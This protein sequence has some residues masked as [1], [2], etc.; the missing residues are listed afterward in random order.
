V[1]QYSYSSRGE[2]LEA[3]TRYLNP[4]QYGAA[5]T[6]AM[7]AG[8][9]WSY[10]FDDTGNLLRKSLSDGSWYTMIDVDD[11]NRISSRNTMSI[12]DSVATPG[13]IV[14]GVAAEGA[15]VYAGGK[16]QIPP[17]SQ[18]ALTRTGT[19]T[20]FK[21]ILPYATTSAPV[22]DDEVFLVAE[23][24]GKVSFAQRQ[25]FVPK[26]QQAFASD[27]DG[28]LTQDGRW[29]YSWNSLSQLTEVRPDPAALA[30]GHP[31]T[32][33]EYSYDSDGWRSEKR[34]YTGG[35]VERVRYLYYGNDLLAEVKETVNANGEATWELARGYHWMSGGVGEA[36]RLLSVQDYERVTT[37]LPGHDERGNVVTWTNC[38]TG[39]LIGTADYGP[40]GE[41]FDVRWVTPADEASYDRFGFGTEYRDETGL[42]YY[43][44]RYY[45]PAL[46]R[47]LS[48]DPAGVAGSGVNLYAFCGGDP[49]NKREFY[50]LCN[51]N[52]YW[53]QTDSQ[54]NSMGPKYSVGSPTDTNSQR[55][56][57]SYN[58]LEDPNLSIDEVFH[59][60]FTGANTSSY[61][62]WTELLYQAPANRMHL[63]D[64]P[65]PNGGGNASGLTKGNDSGYILLGYTNDGNGI[66]I[67]TDLDKFLSAVALW[68]LLNNNVDP[69][70]KIYPGISFF[71]ATEDIKEHNRLDINPKGNVDAQ[72]KLIRT[73]DEWVAGQI[74]R[75]EGDGE[76]FEVTIGSVVKSNLDPVGHSFISI[77]NLNN[78]NVFNIGLVPFSGMPDVANSLFGLAYMRNDQL[79]YEKF[80]KD[81]NAFGSASVEIDRLQFIKLVGDIASLIVQPGNYNIFTRQCAIVANHL[82]VMAGVQDFSDQ[83]GLITW[84]T[85]QYL[86]KRMKK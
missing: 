57:H 45:S 43:G 64:T 7:L 75:L 10:V 2:L 4:S 3:Q 35:N 12:V 52:V 61:G 14:D 73:L 65:K 46:G 24:S 16:K 21:T 11:E 38:A 77:R 40:Y 28:N 66:I 26:A 86:N 60:V 56:D 58:P 23:K 62:I 36:W 41:R 55:N 27:A 67:V 71:S 49:V 59:T 79:D 78:G 25:A 37:A 74:Q 22:Y 13:L 54:W 8:R 1:T 69:I 84:T 42:I 47:F 53:G 6:G 15:K 9:S 34:S 81:P 82:F 50:G 72:L 32:Q 63:Y 30:A 5:P 39:E 33:Y 48:R 18:A 68:Q 80:M 51:G 31:A 20:Y 85:P 29:I 44:A 70:V 76:K 19:G 83:S 17:T